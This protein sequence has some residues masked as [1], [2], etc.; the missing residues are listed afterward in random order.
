MSLPPSD[1]SLPR[2]A[3]SQP[4]PGQG[5]S[6]ARR[7]AIL[8][9]VAV[10]A[11]AAW[12]PLM[13]VNA[14]VSRPPQLSGSRLGYQQVAPYQRDAELRL[15]IILIASFLVILT[16]AT[17]AIIFGRGALRMVASSAALARLRGWG[18]VA[19]AVSLLSLGL[20]IVVTT[21]P[22]PLSTVI[23]IPYAY[24]IR[25][26]LYLALVIVT[27]VAAMSGFILNGIVAHRAAVWTWLSR[28][29]ATLALLFWFLFVAFLAQLTVAFY[30]HLVG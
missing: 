25:Q 6:R 21:M 9:I 16:L 14:F 22:G 7:S 19:L 13:E 12:G 4:P 28:A 11:T 18:T 17:L 30:M 10:I 8:A 2:V 20:G 29:S 3:A 5:R 24:T 26:F 1:N 27:P 23:F 15:W